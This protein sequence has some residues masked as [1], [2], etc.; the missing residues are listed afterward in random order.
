MEGF[1]SFEIV[2]RLGID[3]G[4]LREWLK[5]GYV[6]PSVER[7]AGRGTRS[8]FSRWD[9]YRIEL[10]RTLVDRGF[11]REAAAD[12]A[13]AVSDEAIRR[14]LDSRDRASAPSYPA[15]AVVAHYGE[16]GPGGGTVV[17]LRSGAG[18]IGVLET[19]EP[20]D[21]SN[22]DVKIVINLTRIKERVDRLFGLKDFPAGKS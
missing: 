6:A 19:D 9:L 10:F 2:E 22:P 20:A 18:P 8:V 21:P 15:F 5:R 13:S 14:W 1:S 17:A 4:R 11:S 16:G 3:L 7:A 12:T